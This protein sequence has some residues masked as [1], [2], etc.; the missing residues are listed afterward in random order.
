[1]SSRYY[2]TGVFCCMHGIVRVRDKDKDRAIVC[3]RRNNAT[4]G[5][6]KPARPRHEQYPSHDL[7]H[8]AIRHVTPCDQLFAVDN[9]AV[10]LVLRPSTVSYHLDPPAPSAHPPRR[11]VL[12]RGRL[13]GIQLLT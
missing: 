8:S 7:L 11:S 1:M 3:R 4:V 12:A 10:W 5:K 9:D 13:R 6:L 2:W